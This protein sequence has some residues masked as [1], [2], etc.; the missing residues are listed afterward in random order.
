MLYGALWAMLIWGFLQIVFRPGPLAQT[1]YSLLGALLFSGYIVLDVHLLATR[2]E[3][4]DY[5]WGSVMLYLVS[6]W[7]ANLSFLR[8]IKL[9]GCQPI[10]P[11]K[12]KWPTSSQLISD[13]IVS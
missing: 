4:D 13:D 5:I 2:L 3:V 8:N 9:L 7:A 12:Y 10:I 11:E 6:C 1:I